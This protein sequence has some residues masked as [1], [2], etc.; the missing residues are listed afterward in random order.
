ME[1]IKKIEEDNT[2][3]LNDYMK[4][5]ALMLSLQQDVANKID[6]T[7]FSIQIGRKIDRD[8]ML[9]MIKAL[10]L[11][12]EKTK[13][14]QTD[15][16]KIKKKLKEAIDFVEEKISN[17]KKE[18]D[19][20]YIQ[21]LL[22]SKAEDKDVKGQFKSVSDQMLDQRQSFDQLKKDLENLISAYKKLS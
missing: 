12:E 18:F 5:N 19:M 21:R 7:T 13:K 16:V 17:I 20:P 9:E 14:M 3:I 22:K 1:R 2:R 4:F 15:I 8:E 10:T 6:L 11:D